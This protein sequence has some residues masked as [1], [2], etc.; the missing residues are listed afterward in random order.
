MPICLTC[1]TLEH[2]AHSAIKLEVQGNRKKEQI[3]DECKIFENT[4]C[5]NLKD[6]VAEIQQKISDLERIMT[7]YLRKFFSIEGNGTLK[8]TKL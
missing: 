6:S 3:H 1:I 7:G 2:R 5:K 4:L 8:L